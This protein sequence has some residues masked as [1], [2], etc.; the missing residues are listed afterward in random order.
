MY[1]I[2]TSGRGGRRPISGN[3]I[4]RNTQYLPFSPQKAIS[5]SPMKG[6]D[7]NSIRGKQRI[8]KG[9]G[10]IYNIKST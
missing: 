7:N 9:K 1:I 4:S 10:T 8:N 2:Y 5:S 3:T 6:G